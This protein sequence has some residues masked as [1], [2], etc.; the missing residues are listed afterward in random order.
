MTNG[1]TT[2]SGS[3]SESVRYNSLTGVI[4]TPTYLAIPLNDTTGVFLGATMPPPGYD[5]YSNF[6]FK[7][8]GHSN[9]TI[10]TALF[11]NNGSSG[12]LTPWWSPILPQITIRSLKVLRLQRQSPNPPHS[13][14]LE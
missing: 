1:V 2:Y 6:G 14:S 11:W 5:G 13:R 4:A 10:L 12:T 3:S 8:G 7:F 9:G